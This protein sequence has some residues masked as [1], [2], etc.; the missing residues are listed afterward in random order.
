MAITDVEITKLKEMCPVAGDLDLGTL[1]RNAESGGLVAGDGV[2]ITDGTV[3][4]V[5][6]DTTVAIGDDGIQVKDG[7]VDTDQLADGAVTAD[8]LDSGVALIEDPLGGPAAGERLFR[9]QVALA[10]GNPT[11]LLFSAPSLAAT[12][13]SSEDGPFALTVGNT[14][15]INPNAVGNQTWT[16][17]GAAGTSTGVAG[18]KTDMSAEPETKLKVAV[19]GGA[20]VSFTFDWTA[21]G[22][23]NTG[24]KVAAQMQTVIRVQG[25]DFAAVTVAYSTDHYVITS[26]NKGTTS[27][28]VVTP[29]ADHDCSAELKLGVANGGTEAAGT[30]DVPIL[31]RAMA[32]QV[33]TIIDALHAQIVAVAE[34]TKVRISATGTGGSSSLVVGNGTENTELGFTNTQ[35]DYGNVGL[36]LAKDMAN[37]TYT[38]MLTPVTNAPGTSDVISAYNKATTGFDIYAETPTAGLLVDVLV[39]GTPAA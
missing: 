27:A 39:V 24:A 26:G 1:I 33:A 6:D 16:V 37:A 31:A 25:G 15:I 28:V 18:A 13:L 23:C 11:S 22:G 38:V 19:D 17:T 34:G 32:A 21:G 2:D 3:S 8:K 30:G 4:T 9:G 14:F 35:S 29:A 5:V 10:G 20:A 12:L 7:G 36:G